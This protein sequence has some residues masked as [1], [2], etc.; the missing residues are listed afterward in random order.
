M[1][2]SWR[3]GMWVLASA[4]GPRRGALGFTPSLGARTEGRGAR[5]AERTV[6]IQAAVLTSPVPQA[7]P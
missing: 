1:C 3:S 4:A 2:M 7:G 6:R 5:F